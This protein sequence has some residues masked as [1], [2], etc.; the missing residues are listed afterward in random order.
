[1]AEYKFE[2]D[3]KAW[4]KKENLSLEELFPL[5]CGLCP[6]AYK[7]WKKAYEPQRRNEEEV[8]IL[9]QTQEFYSKRDKD[10]NVEDIMVWLDFFI[11]N[12]KWEGDKNTIM[13][14]FYSNSFPQRINNH[15]LPSLHP[16][17]IAFLKSIGELPEYVEKYNESYYDVNYGSLDINDIDDEDAAISV[18]FGC[19]IEPFKRW[20]KFASGKHPVEDRAADDNAFWMAC[21]K[22]FGSGSSIDDGRYTY[23]CYQDLKRLGK[24]NGDFIEYSKTLYNEGVIY[25][26]DAQ[27]Y[28][29]NNGAKLEYAEES[30]AYKF[31][32]GWLEKDLWTLEQALCLFKGECPNA[33][34]NYLDF[35]QGKFAAYGLDWMKDKYTGK[36]DIKISDAIRDSIDAGKLHLASQR[37]GQLRF[38]PKDIVEWLLD[39]TEHRPPKP[40]LNLL[41]IKNED[42]SALSISPTR[43][44]PEKEKLDIDKKVT[45]F[46]KEYYKK[47]SKYANQDPCIKHLQSNGY[48]M[49]GDEVLKKKFN[50]TEIKKK[51]R[52]GSFQDYK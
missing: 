4:W 1:M 12:K 3:Y 11:D 27:S 49:Q 21:R 14:L 48:G 32:E 50:N 13:D 2:P 35:S 5:A 46:Q 52:V 19:K 38:A 24:W 34:R 22:Y 40:L 6:N 17:F 33:G 28:L 39:K 23:H 10:A 8:K 16:D 9:Q 7:R 20:L 41:G 18:L 30:W 25:P 36:L 47:H 43:L 51:L 29:G 15:F 42:I 45:D 44:S 26:K 37:D 31:Y